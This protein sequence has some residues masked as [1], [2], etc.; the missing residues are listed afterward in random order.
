MD[1]GIVTILNIRNIFPNTIEFRN[2]F[3]VIDCFA[4]AKVLGRGLDWGWIGV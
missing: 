3:L 2:I 1:W 4:L